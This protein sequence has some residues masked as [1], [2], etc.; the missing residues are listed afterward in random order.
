M[1]RENPDKYTLQLRKR[2]YKAYQKGPK[3]L[4]LQRQEDGA[5]LQEFSSSLSDY[6]LVESL[7]AHY[8]NLP[9]GTRLY[10]RD[11]KSWRAVSDREIRHAIATHHFTTSS[12][13]LMWSEAF[14]RQEYAAAKQEKDLN[15]RR[16]EVD[17]VFFESVR[18][19]VVKNSRDH[20]VFSQAFF[21]LF[22]GDL[23]S[24]R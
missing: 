9:Q 13:V 10:R 6:A 15:V 2:L 21:D 20:E 23:S 24:G 7:A 12:N 4:T 17:D 11:D 19:A 18:A 22:D 14:S 3:Y 8:P 5:D 1:V 16:A